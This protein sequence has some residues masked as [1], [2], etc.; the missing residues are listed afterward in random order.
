VIGQHFIRPGK[1]DVRFARVLARA[2]ADRKDADYHCATTFTVG[3]AAES[4]ASAREFLS[5]VKA[6]LASA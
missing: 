4:L 1:L 3:D 6:L 2:A 5:A